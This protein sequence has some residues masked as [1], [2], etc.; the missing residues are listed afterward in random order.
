MENFFLK[1]HFW[2]SFIKD[3]SITKLVLDRQYKIDLLAQISTELGT[4]NPSVFDRFYNYMADHYFFYY[5]SIETYLAQTKPSNSR[6]I[7]YCL[8]FLLVILTTIKYGV[9]TLSKSKSIQV[10]L[11]EQFFAYVPQY[12]FLNALILSQGV[13]VIL[14]KMAML[15]FDIRHEVNVVQ[16]SLLILSV[17]LKYRFN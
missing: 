14:F 17:D 7:F 9:L 2:K 8:K 6:R 5:E 3:I 4:F 12:K 11:G 10:H 1:F 15:Y 16:V 13:F